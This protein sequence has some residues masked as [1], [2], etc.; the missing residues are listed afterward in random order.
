LTDEE[1]RQGEEKRPLPIGA[2]A[3]TISSH[4]TRWQQSPPLRRGSLLSSGAMTSASSPQIWQWVTLYIS[5]SFRSGDGQRQRRIEVVADWWLRGGGGGIDIDIPM[6][7]H[8][9]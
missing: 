8:R 7:V 3:G 1:G 9:P 6:V 2:L 4:A 5:I